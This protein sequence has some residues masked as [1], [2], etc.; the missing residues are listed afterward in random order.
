MTGEWTAEDAAHELLAV[1][2]LIN[3]IVAGAVRRETSEETTMSQFRVLAL[4]SRGPQTLSV[5]ARQRRVSLQ[6]VGGQV[7]DLVERGWVQRTSDPRDRRQHFLE[8]TD[9]GRERYE[10]ATEQ[11]LRQLVPLLQGLTP[12][13]LRA[14]RLALPALARVLTGGERDEPAEAG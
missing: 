11:T 6:A 10:R 4:L 7:Q 2:P 5:L 1:L 9:L 12:E 14:V 13:E 8:L 3:R